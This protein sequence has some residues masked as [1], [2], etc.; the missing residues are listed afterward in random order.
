MLWKHRNNDFKHWSKVVNF[1]KIYHKA[2]CEHLLKELMQLL[3]LII[4]DKYYR[5]SQIGHG[6]NYCCVVFWG[7]DEF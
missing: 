5:S 1:L 7:L 3:F 2:I 4:I 6:M